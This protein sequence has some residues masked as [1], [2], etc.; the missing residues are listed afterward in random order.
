MLMMPLAMRI[1]TAINR[2]FEPHLDD[3]TFCTGAGMPIVAMPAIC[4]V[5]DAFDRFRF[6]V[7]IASRSWRTP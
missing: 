1:G 5:T 2:N 6:L 4:W 7:A 3:A